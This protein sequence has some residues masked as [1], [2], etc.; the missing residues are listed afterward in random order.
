MKTRTIL[1]LLTA[2]F[3][4]IPLA[5]N[6]VSAEELTYYFDDYNPFV[7]WPNNPGY[8]VDGSLSTFASTSTESVQH[9]TGTVKLS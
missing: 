5:G 1:C 4:I 6:T 2:A 3:F 9:L 8:M 7:C